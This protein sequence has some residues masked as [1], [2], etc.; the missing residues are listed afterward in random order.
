MN[1]N[2]VAHQEDGVQFYIPSLLMHGT[3]QS[4]T[5][6]LLVADLLQLVDRSKYVCLNYYQAQIWCLF[7]NNHPLE[8][9]S[10]LGC[11]IGSKCKFIG[12]DDYLL[13]RVDDCSGGSHFL[14]CKCSRERALGCGMPWGTLNGR[15]LKV[16]GT[17]KLQWCELEVEYFEFCDDMQL[18]I[19][20]WAK[21]MECRKKLQVPWTL[22]VPSVLAETNERCEG[23]DYIQQL[24]KAN[25]MDD[26]VIATPCNSLMPTNQTMEKKQPQDRPGEPFVREPSIIVSCSVTEAK[27]YL[28]RFLISHQYHRISTTELFQELSDLLDQVAA[29]KFQQQNLAVHVKP[30]QQ[31][32]TDIFNEMLGK[33]K[34]AGLAQFPNGNVF[35]WKSLKTLHKYSVDRT[36]SLLKLQCSAGVLDHNYIRNKLINP[37]LTDKAILNVFKESLRAICEAYPQF[38]ASWW[39]DVDKNSSVIHFEYP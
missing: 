11:V 30:W 29:F 19:H 13:F 25:M 23:L 34:Q 26:M 2:H 18:E 31:L 22:D 28:L 17:F 1:Y 27:V 35:D 21:A 39:I 9:V 6:P 4:V 8:K 20:H 37:D 3:Y 7:W 16:Y 15:R 38:L 12:D 33:L 10:V 36:W 24:F 5:V 32:R 14:N